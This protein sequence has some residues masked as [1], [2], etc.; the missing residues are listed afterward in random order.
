MKKLT[1]F[2]VLPFYFLLFTLAF[3]LAAYAGQ[4]TA[5]GYFYKPSMG[6]S[7][8]AEYNLFNQG[9]DRGDAELFALDPPPPLS[10]TPPLTYNSATGVLAI[11]RASATANGYLASADWIGFNAKEPAITPGATSQYWRGD[12]TWQLLDAGAVKIG[13]IWVGDPDYGSTIQAA[14][15]SINSII[16]SPPATLHIPAGTYT[17]SSSYTIPANITLAPERGAILSVPAGV[18]LTISGGFE[19]GLYQVFSCAGTGSVVFGRPSGIKELVPQ[20]WGATGDDIHD[21]TAALNAMAVCSVASGSIPMFCP[22]G[23]YKLTNTLKLNLGSN[24]AGFIFRGAGS[25]RGGGQMTIFDASSFGDRPAIN[26]QSA[27]QVQL[28]SFAV[29]GKNVAPLTAAFDM[30]G[31]LPDPVKANWITSGCIDSQYAPYC[32]ISVDAYTGSKLSGGYSND[33]YGWGSSSGV[34]LEDVELT[35]FVV[36]LMLSPTSNQDGSFINVRD[37]EIAYNTYGVSS[38]SS[39]SDSINIYNTWIEWS[40][41]GVTNSTHGQQDGHIPSWWGGGSVGLWKIFELVGQNPCV[42]SG[43]HNEA[44]IWLGNL[45]GDVKFEG[46]HFTWPGAG[47]GYYE[48]YFFTAEGNISFD[49]CDFQGY[50]TRSIFNFINLTGPTTWVNCNWYSLLSGSQ[51]FIGIASG[52]QFLGY[53]FINCTVSVAGGYPGYPCVNNECLASYPSRQTILPWVHTLRSWSGSNG[54]TNYHITQPYNNGMA[55]EV[56]IS[57]ASITGTDHNAVLRFTA[58]NAPDWMV[59]DIIMW[60]VSARSGAYGT[61]V[62]PAF[63]VTNVTGTTVTA[64]SLVD[65]VNTTWAPTQVN[66]VMPLFF[67][68]TPAT[69]NTHS[70]TTVDNVTNI[71]NFAVGDWIQGAGIASARIVSINVSGNSFQMSRNASSSNTGVSI[72]NCG[73]T[74][75]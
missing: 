61:P 23:T 33:P 59:G 69:G 67:N 53:Q 38:G 54:F 46:G 8:Q 50:D 68:G 71:G 74:T 57:G 27:R 21:D 13:E 73:L 5:H 45:E 62:V 66:V 47:S 1:V 60:Q 19:A 42:I 10:A 64:Q 75:Y 35:Q 72:Y 25:N 29:V 58:G 6:A 28:K 22:G 18:T 31:S 56:Q 39:Q 11:P 55:Y 36:G 65:L 20:W 41:C 37:S 43:T 2:L 70:N 63:Q 12:K 4:W 26:V 17:F 24:L 7:G 48:P 14:I 44:F 32:G 9:L 3:C 34:F 30:P 52:T 49:S 15:T 40:W 51:G 16:F